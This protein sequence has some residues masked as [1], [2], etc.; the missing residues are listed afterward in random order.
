MSV[1]HERDRV[2]ID[3]RRQSVFGY[4]VVNDDPSLPVPRQESRYL[5]SI[6]NRR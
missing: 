1:G 3:R 4:Y 5:V 6:S 2:S